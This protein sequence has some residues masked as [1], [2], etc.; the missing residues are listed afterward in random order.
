MCFPLLENQPEIPFA[1]F[2]PPSMQF[3]SS[4]S[5]DVITVLQEGV[6][7]ILATMCSA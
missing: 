5:Y 4:A 1:L 2:R 3:T 6:C 7:G